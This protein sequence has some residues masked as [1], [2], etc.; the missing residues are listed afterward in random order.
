MANIKDVKTIQAAESLFDRLSIKGKIY[1]IQDAKAR[2]AIDVLNGTDSTEGSVAK[3][4]KDALTTHD[5]GKIQVNATN[6]KTIGTGK[7]IS[8]IKIDTDGT[9]AATETDLTTSQVVRTATTA[10]TTGTKQIALSGT[11][12]EAALIELAQAIAA[13]IDNRANG[14]TS[15]I[16][17]NQDDEDD[18]TIYGAKA[19]AK[20]L[21]DDI[22][23]GDSESA[24]DKI[25]TIKALYEELKGSGDGITDTLIDKFNTLMAGLGK[26]GTGAEEHDT[27][28]KE[29]V[30]AAVAAK[31]VSATGDTTY[32]TATASN[33]SVEVA[34]TTKTAN[35]VGY[36]ETALQTISG[37]TGNDALINVS[38]KSGEVGAKTSEISATTK[39]SDAV[40]LAETSVQSVNNI[41]PTNGSVVINATNIKINGENDAITVAQA[42]SNTGAA[43]KTV[44]QEAATNPAVSVT[45]TTAGDGHDIY[46]VDL[47]VS[48]TGTTLVIG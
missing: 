1:E 39:L 45:K 11:T 37:E 22:L 41:T 40:A 5:S 18:D 35:A 26:T 46:T 2:E 16:G 33:N 19:Y 24:Q 28:V 48:V 9:I 42:L 38:A 21:V 31:N 43:S 36:A 30:D 13:E 14:N 8:T 10:V 20:A 32:V 34:V 27:T 3:S 25:T 15:L 44:V 4:I 6:Q 12:T 17:T 23:G 47:S 29:Y 7:I